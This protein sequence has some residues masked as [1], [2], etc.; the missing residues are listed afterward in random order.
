MRIAIQ[1]ILT[2]AL[3]I[4]PAVAEAGLIL[5]NGVTGTWSVAPPPD[6]N[7]NPFWDNQSQDCGGGDCGVYNAILN[8]QAGSYNPNDGILEY[9]HDGNGGAVAFG[10]TSV[11]GWTPIYSSTTCNDGFPG[12][13]ANTQA[14]TYTINLPC[15]DGQNPNFFADSLNNPVQ[16]AL[17]R[18]VGQNGTR[19]YFAFEDKAGTGSDRDYNDLIMSLSPSRV[20][21]PTAL[22]LLGAGL[23]GMAVRR[24]RRRS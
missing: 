3:L 21:E 12:R 11:A 4:S 2:A 19:Y 8:P 15:N 6:K 16:F 10:F 7:G 14:I 18:Q 1:G 13:D 9:L 5:P 24:L 22:A 17:F 20:P 23:M